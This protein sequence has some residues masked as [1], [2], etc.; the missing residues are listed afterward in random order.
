MSYQSHSRRVRQTLSIAIALALIPGFSTA[1][2]SAENQSATTLDTLVVSG[3]AAGSVRKLEASFNILTVNAEKMQMANPKSTAD[4]LKI[5]PGIWTETS[6]GQTGA[7]TII[8]GFP[9]SSGAPHFSVLLMGS[10][11]Y[12][13]PHL[14]FGGPTSMFRLDDTIESV[15]I[16]QGGPSVVFADGQMG[17]SG[18]FFLKTGTEAP[19]GSVGLTYG[20][21]GLWRLDGF[22]GFKLADNWYGS[23]GGFWRESDGIRDPQ[24]KA[25]KGGQL[26]ATISHDLDAGRMTLY[27]RHLN[28]KNQ[29]ITPIPL[30]QNGRDKFSAYPGFDPLKDTYYSRAMQHVRLPTWPGGAKDVDLAD[31]RGTRLSMLGGNF[32]YEFDNGWSISERFLFNHADMYTNALFSGNNPVSLQDMLYANVPGGFNIQPGANVTAEYVTGG[33]VALDQSVI[34]QGWWHVHKRMKSFNNEFRLSKELFSG[35]TL[36]AGFYIARYSSDD[37]Y[38]Q[39]NQ[40]L[41]ANEPN[42]RP[43]TVRYVDGGQTFQRTDAQGFANF[44][45]TH[46]AQ[47]GTATNM[48]LYLS[49]SWRI[50]NWLMDLSGRLENQDLKYKVCNRSRVNFGSGGLDGDASTLYDNDVQMCDGSFTHHRYDKSHPSWTAGANYTFNRHMSAYGRVNTGGHFLD[51]DHGIR[52][53]VNGNY[54]PIQKI[55]N[56]EIGF[57]Y[58]SQWVYADISAYRRDF[59]GLQYQATDQFGVR[60]GETKTYGSETYG[61]NFIGA[62]TPVKNMRIELVANYADGEYTD[63]AACFPYIDVNG[64]NDCAS[65][66]GNQ[67]QR[68]PKFR[69]MLTP[70]YRFDLEWGAITPYLIYSHVGNRTQDQSGLQYL[71]SYHTLDFGIS[72]NVGE[73]WQFNLRGNNMTNELGLT[74][75]NS[76]I[77]GAASGAGGVLLARPLEGREI[78][79]QAKYLW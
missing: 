45:G 10:P 48:A 39:G 33:N 46:L 4:L 61:L 8:A 53:T 73:H 77:F 22:S 38:S 30:I 3:T 36:T 68:Q 44:G 62:L 54:P 15:E 19:S 50:G 5:S 69:A 49:D 25:D 9:S 60:T 34:Q 52:G 79:F 40:M 2:E 11:I 59:S 72:A 29:F 27:A 24:F 37:K 7:N 70:S 26:T 66:E 63:Y 64:D 23:I 1:Q 28:D 17:A 65:I 13:A 57:K 35:N 43:I 41:M 6:G 31:G 71:G 16:L 78:N 67:L 56:Y 74:E 21:E 20:N 55:R 76:R 75:S 18:N 12:G 51:F 47:D 42:A 32:E 58:Q 14:S